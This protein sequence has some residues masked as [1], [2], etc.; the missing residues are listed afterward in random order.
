MKKIMLTMAL[1]VAATL[2]HAGPDCRSGVDHKVGCGPQYRPDHR[3]NEYER[4]RHPHYQSAWR[5]NEGWVIPALIIGGIIAVEANRSPPVVIEQPV[6]VQSQ[7]TYLPQA[8]YGYRYVNALDPACN[9]NKIVLV[10]N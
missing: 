10:P 3:F 6:Y 8:P 5:G 9:C 4:N 2:A 7:P 1:A